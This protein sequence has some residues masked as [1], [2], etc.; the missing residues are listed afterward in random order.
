MAKLFDMLIEDHRNIKQMLDQTITNKDPS[1]FPGIK[2]E[3]E[4][5]MGGEE[6]YFYPKIME[7]DKETA[8]VSFEEHHIGKVVL[9]ELDSTSQNDESWMP[10]V[11]VLRDI[12]GHHMEE[13]E[14]EV[15][16]AAQDMMDSN[17]EQQIARQIE[18]FKH[19]RM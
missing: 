13:E 18:E 4:V 16:L 11:K 6:R 9:N 15:F 3:L 10:K 17:D 2:K 7:Q 12:I 19:Q 1:Q 14:D 5:H 8:L